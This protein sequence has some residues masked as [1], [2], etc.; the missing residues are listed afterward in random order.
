MSV[1]I[2]EALEGKS[3]ESVVIDD[4]Y[5]DPTPLPPGHQGEYWMRRMVPVVRPQFWLIALGLT[6]AVVS[7]ILRVEVPNVVR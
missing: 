7:M 5:R 1:V 2:N 4:S 6:A 3:L